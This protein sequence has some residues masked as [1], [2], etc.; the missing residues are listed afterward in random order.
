MLYEVH[1][2]ITTNLINLVFFM[3]FDIIPSEIFCYQRYHTKYVLYSVIYIISSAN[4]ICVNIYT[5]EF[6]IIIAKIYYIR[7][8]NYEAKAHHRKR[9]YRNYS[10]FQWNQQHIKKI[11]M[12]KMRITISNIKLYLVI[13]NN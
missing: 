7:S 10:S 11:T 13:N 8:L 2:V 9:N 5:I 12:K 4:E 1:L 6:V 3:F